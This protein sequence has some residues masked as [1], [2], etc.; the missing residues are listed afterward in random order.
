LARALISVLFLL[1]AAGA[2]AATWRV[3][4]DG[5][6]DFTVIQD[7]VNVAASGDTI[8]I[9]PGRFNEGT[10]VQV[11]G[12]TELVRVLVTV[13]DL[14]LIGAGPQETIIG[15]EADWDLSQGWHRGIQTATYWGTRRLVVE[16]IRFENMAYAINDDDIAEVEIRNCAF[17][18][19]HYSVGDFGGSLLIAN[20]DF[21]RV[22]RDGRHLV[23]WAHER[24]R[25]SNCT[26]LHVPDGTW[27]QSSIGIAGVRDATFE[28]CHFVG[29][30]SGLGVSSG[31]TASVRRCQFD[32]M[33]TGIYSGSGC[34]LTVEDCTL[35]GQG[36][37]L[38]LSSDWVVRR[39]VIADVSYV[40]LWIVEF[41][42]GIMNDCYL[43]K[44]PSFVVSNGREPRDAEKSTIHYDL[45]NNSWGTTDPDSIQAWIWDK[46]DDPEAGYIVDWRP[47]IGEPV[48]NERQPLGSIK[49]LFR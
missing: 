11:P 17:N 48:S 2:D 41:G 23:G 13:E 22:K 44:G 37:A 45:T 40:S 20:V 31:T 49:S 25:V 34:N 18:G 42:H 36:L 26:F 14:T 29:G 1:C 7:A 27:A 35:T 4:R 19:N 39:T 12:W 43:A 38:R 15:Q 33:Y 8:R 3:E 46:N 21:E 32:N 47:Y 10:I 9:G 16:G 28:D 5:S 6:G 30:S 24:L